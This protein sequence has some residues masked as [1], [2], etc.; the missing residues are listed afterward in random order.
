MVYFSLYSDTGGGQV[1][2]RSAF[3]KDIFRYMA[4]PYDR[5]NDDDYDGDLVILIII[6]FGRL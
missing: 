5:H 2:I 3:L 4:V 6:I 1:H